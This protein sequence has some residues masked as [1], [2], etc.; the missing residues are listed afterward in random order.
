MSNRYVM[1][2]ALKDV[3]TSSTLQSCETDK[4]LRELE[5]KPPS[6]YQVCAK[7]AINLR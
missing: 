4:A 2:G 5:N 1:A 6:A 3:T 7:L